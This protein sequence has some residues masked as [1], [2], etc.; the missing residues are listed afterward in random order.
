MTLGGSSGEV[1]Y[2]ALST[3][4]YMVLTVPLRLAELH[5]TF[6]ESFASQYY[7]LISILAVSLSIWPVAWFRLGLLLSYH[8]VANAC[9][10]C[11]TYHK[12]AGFSFSFFTKLSRV[13]ILAA[14]SFVNGWT[15]FFNAHQL[16]GTYRSASRQSHLKITKAIN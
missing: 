16:S 8:Y 10:S 4:L 11:E 13:S 15:T 1:P 3:S 12:N 6:E 7:S 9:R 2:S 14:L 5:I